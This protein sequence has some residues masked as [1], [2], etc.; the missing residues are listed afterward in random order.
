METSSRYMKNCAPRKHG[1]RGMDA[2][3]IPTVDFHGSEHVDGHFKA[4]VYS[5]IHRL[6]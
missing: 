5:R 2:Y 6:C 3:L 4:S 1:E